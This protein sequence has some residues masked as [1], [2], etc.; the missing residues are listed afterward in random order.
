MET[1]VFTLGVMFGKHDAGIAKAYGEARE[2]FASI[3]WEDG[4][5]A[6]YAHPLAA[7]SVVLAVY[8][9]GTQQQSS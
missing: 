6:L 1:I 4:G 7:L 2:L 8:R 9:V 5:A 3:P